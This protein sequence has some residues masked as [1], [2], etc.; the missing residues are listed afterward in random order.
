M[1]EQIEREL[2]VRL[3]E[4]RSRYE[5]LNTE[6]KSCRAEIDGI[7]AKL[8]EM[9]TAQGKTATAKYEGLGF[10]GLEKPELY[11]NC[12]KENEDTLFSY[13]A[14]I[15]RSDLVRSSVHP[16]TLSSFV[17]ECLEQ[18]KGL[19][20]FISYYLKPSVKFYAR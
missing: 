16:R 1:A 4:E 19:P 10:V 15:G 3:R 20:E 12:R 8:I 11:A 5:K 13:L 18:G 9:L 6:L 2:V 14:E 7:E 17:K